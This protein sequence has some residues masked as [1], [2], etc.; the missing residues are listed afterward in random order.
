MDCFCHGEQLNLFEV[1]ERDIE[2]DDVVSH[3]YFQ[4]Q[5]DSNEFEEVSA[6]IISTERFKKIGNDAVKTFQCRQ[7]KKAYRICLFQRQPTSAE[8]KHHASMQH[9]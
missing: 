7:H 9:L 2:M 8:V 5:T 6:D 4:Y 1:T 3:R